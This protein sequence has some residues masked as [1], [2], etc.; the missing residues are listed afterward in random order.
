MQIHLERN[1]NRDARPVYRQIADHIRREIDA[2]RVVAGS[3][4]PP[5]RDLARRLQVNRDT[6]A[7]A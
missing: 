5:I 4:L 3:R 6:V 7:L 1:G 2:R